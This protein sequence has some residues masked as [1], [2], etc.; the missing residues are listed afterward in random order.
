VSPLLLRGAILAALAA[1]GVLLALLSLPSLFGRPWSE[2]WTGLWTRAAFLAAF[3]ALVAA[4][5]A[6]AAGP[7]AHVILHLGDWFSRE[8][9]F[10]F[11]LLIDGWSLSFAALSVGICGIVSSFSFR[12]LHR[13]EGF[14]RYFMLLVAFVGGLELVALAGSVEVLFA[15]WEILGLSSALLVAFFH[16]R[17]A[18]VDNAFRVLTF[19]RIGDAC[20]LTAAV[21]LH[22][23]AGSDSLSLLFSGDAGRLARL[24][25]GSVVVIAVLILAA[26]AA[27]SALLPFSTWLPRA[28]EGPTPSSAVYYGALSVHAG[29]YLLLRSE[30]LVRY[31]AATRV[32]TGA[33]GLAT[34][35]YAAL[36]GRAQSDVKSRL[37]FASL[38]QVGIIVAEIALGWDLLAFVHMTGNICLRLLQFLSAPNVLHD[39]HELENDRGAR[40]AAA[41]EP[42]GPFARALYLFALERGF[43]DGLIDRWV[44]R[45]LEGLAASMGRLDRWL[46]RGLLATAGGAD[47]A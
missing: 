7:R 36:V 5:L 11:D 24:D 42:P 19:Y 2:E 21:L 6:Y 4:G 20:M 32:L 13:E 41:D 45:P 14:H 46:C 35:A 23:W 28:M 33:V 1:P 29:C 9:G 15:G 44:A 34:A 31:S 40:L 8:G 3:G 27:K 26:A 18:P 17:P 16:D 10:A 43:L 12:Y 38:T 39:L 22:H 37:C 25:A 30:A 47:D